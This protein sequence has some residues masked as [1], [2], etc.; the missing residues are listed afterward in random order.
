MVSPDGRVRP[1]YKPTGTRTTR[2]SCEL[3][4]LQQI[5]RRSD[6][7]WS[8]PVKSLFIPTNEDWV[9][10]DFDYASLEYRIA[11]FYAGE[12]EL[13]ERVNSGADFH[14]VTADLIYE[15]TGVRLTRYDAKQMNFAI[16]YGAGAE[17]LAYMLKSTR[18]EHSGKAADDQVA[19][20]IKAYHTAFPGFRR[21]ARDL[22]LI[23]I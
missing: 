11:L 7:P 2:L 22:S 12:T 23:H 20:L 19:K 1:N 8:G 10:W 18:D 3:P 17:K 14:E 5:P 4:N 15:Q 13:I 16:V 6:K 21:T 9:L